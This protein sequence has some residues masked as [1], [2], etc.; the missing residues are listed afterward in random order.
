M[1][2]P[3]TTATCADRQS[4]REMGFC[5]GGKRRH[6]FVPQMDPL[7]SFVL[8]NRIRDAVERIAGDGDVTLF[9]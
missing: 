8:A 4:S 7:H 6:L 5:S 3:R 1:Q 9:V 2:I